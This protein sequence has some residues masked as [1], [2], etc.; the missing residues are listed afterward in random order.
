[1]LM[2]AKSG[3]EP[4]VLAWWGGK[5]KVS[6]S[7]PKLKGHSSTN[8]HVPRQNPLRLKD[9]LLALA[10]QTV[11]SQGNALRDSLGGDARRQLGAGDCSRDTSWPP[12]NMGMGQN[13]TTR[14]GTAG[15]SLWFHLP[16]FHLGCLFLT[17]SHTKP[18]MLSQ[19]LSRTRPIRG[20]FPP[21][22]GLNPTTN[23]GIP[24]PIKINQGFINPG[25]AV[26]LDHHEI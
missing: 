3:Q 10:R 6:K 4:Q 8:G 14:N 11:S 23:R 15:F 7:H 26:Q 22:S 17:H 25:L 20:V 16:G 19:D 24:P 2:C 1:M 13:K 5:T 12:V 21:K 9:P 18:I